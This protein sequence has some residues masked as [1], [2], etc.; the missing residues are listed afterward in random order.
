MALFLWVIWGIILS[1]ITRILTNPER[2]G[3]E[4]ITRTEFKLTRTENTLIRNL[5]H[6]TSRS[7]WKYFSRSCPDI[8]IYF[9]Y[10]WTLKYY[11]TFW[12]NL[13]LEFLSLIA[14]NFPLPVLTRKLRLRRD[15]GYVFLLHILR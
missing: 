2:R 6:D 11:A 12:L 8:F 5:S 15:A 3:I 14:T 4:G 10:H 7:V 9:R 13:H 1:R